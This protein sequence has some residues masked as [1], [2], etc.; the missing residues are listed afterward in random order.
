MKKTIFRTFLCAVSFLFF[1]MA[2]A[3]TV[4]GTVTDDQGPLP[5]ANVSVK[6]T[7]N[8]TTTDFDGN[9]TLNDVPNDATLVFSFIGY[10]TQEIPVDSR[11]TID[12]AMS[13]DASELE[14][15]V[16]IGYGQTTVKDATGAVSS[17]KAEDFNKGV[18]TSP[19][20]LLQGRVAGVQ[21]TGSSGEPGAAA[22]IRVRG[23]SSIRAGNDPLIVVDGVP[24]SG[25]GVSAGSDV[26]F[27]RQSSR[28]PLSFI[29]SSDIQ[30]IDILKDASATAIYG[31][32]GAN[33]VILITTKGGRT[34]KPQISFNSSFQFGTIANEYDLISAEDY[35]GIAADV[36]NPDPDLGARLDPMG[37]ILR[38]A[39]TQQHDFSYGSGGETGNFRMSLG[40]LDQ[41]GIVKGTGQEKYTGNINLTQRAFKDVVTFKS[42]VIYSYIKDDGEA[43][44]D[45]VGA[46]GDLLFSTLRWNPTRP[47]YKD[48]GTY[49]QP[50]DN[51]RNPLAFLEYYED[52]T[53]T[54][55][56]LAN[57]SATVHITDELD[58]KFNVGL[59]R[60]ESTRRAAVSSLFNTNN[61]LD[62]GVASYEDTYNFSKLFEHTLSYNSNLTEDLELDAV[63]GY[64]Y[65]SFEA[66]GNR[67][68][69]RDFSIGDQDK[70][71]KDIGYAS[72]FQASEVTAYFNPSSELQSYFGRVNF[73]YLKKYLLTATLRADGSS[74]FGANNRYG[75][76]PSVGAAW[77]IVEE[78]FLPDVV[79]ELKLR[80]SWGITGNQE[81]PAGSAQTQFGPTDDGSA[82]QQVNV[83][84]PNLQWESTEQYGVGFDFGFF[85][86]RL[87]GSIDYFNRKT[88]DLLFRLPAIQPAPDVDFYTNFD[89]IEIVNEGVE[90]SFNA[91]IINT[92][93]YGFN[94]SYNMA[95]L[96]NEINNVSNQ[97]PIGI[98]T[99]EINGR[100]LTGQNAQ[101]LYDN[102]PLYT[103]YLPVF[104]GYDESGAPIY[105][106]VNG[107]GTV[108]PNFDGPGG[109]SDRTFVGN[110]NPDITLGIALNGRYKNFDFS[111]NLNGAYG[112]KVFDNTA[113]ALFYKAAVANG[114]NA[115]YEEVNSEADAENGGPF[116]STK[117]LQSGD[118][119]RL[120]SASVGYTFVPEE[121]TMTWLKSLRLYVAG[122]NLFVITPYDGFDPEVD[123]NKEVDGVPSFGI[124][125]TAYPRSRSFTVGINA[126]F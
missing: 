100:S 102:Q 40:F 113:A 2:Q 19:D 75:Y 10:V 34:G 56:I 62:R 25:G 94:V 117:N 28:N 29:N 110:P 48:D 108:N 57:L 105:R 125:Y 35:P 54:S 69:G 31:S 42:N 30:S 50:S 51:Q 33:G 109:T 107:D 12:V 99:G 86:D 116:L 20:Q 97:F 53:E 71:I 17:V 126:N 60:S 98:P 77:R 13:P 37:E 85:M 80:A 44:S 52:K 122:Q 11:E 38:T 49:N 120:N 103:F 6:G 22:N 90:V 70:Y 101:L 76:F 119:L 27:G 124:D 1:S 78:G 79:S 64:S 95:F 3:Q 88:N 72:T 5:G 111:A 9:Y 74:K 8:G 55:R 46:E 112:Q 73:N 66:K 47:F 92:Q 15:V 83:A 93:D 59:D 32:R 65:Q 36:G 43:I 68:I 63:L 84:N 123:T 104:E 121:D 45:N 67:L 14:E 96:N 106:D 118:Y 91:D 115:T 18:N 39:F 114:D 87:T 61:T 23:T 82:I 58:Y 4:S 81:F 89:D 26:G 21:I 24:L 16:L 7:T 41:E